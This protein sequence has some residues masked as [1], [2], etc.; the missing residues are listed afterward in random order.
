M[1]SFF[2]DLN[3]WLA[4]S[5]SGN[6]RAKGAWA[7]WQ[8]LPSD[9]SLLFCRFTQ[10]GLLRLLTNP[11]V[12]GDYAY[13]LQ[14]GWAVYD[15]WLNDPRVQ[16]HPEPRSLDAAFATPPS[17]SLINAPRNGSA[18]AI[19]WH[20]PSNLA[21][22][23]SPSTA[24]S[25]PSRENITAASSSPATPPDINIYGFYRNTPLHLLR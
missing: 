20:S 1:T 8:G 17:L 12:M 3:V 7:W 2:P 23:S 6:S 25:P 15:R 13:T 22:R 18:I 9:C 4:L 24:P 10:L 16:F 11:S 21:Q 5:D 14:G 19:S